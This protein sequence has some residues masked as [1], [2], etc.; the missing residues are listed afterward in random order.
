[1]DAAAPHAQTEAQA[2]WLAPARLGLGL[3]AGLGLLALSRAAKAEVIEGPLVGALGVLGALLPFVLLAGMGGMRARVLGLWAGIAGCVLFAVGWRDLE[4]DQPVLLLAPVMLFIAHHLVQA[5]AAAGRWRAPYG[6]Y[7]DLAWRHGVQL[8]LAAAF[9][10]AMWILLWLAAALFNMLGV[11]F[12]EKLITKDY[13][14]FPVTGLAIAAAV[15]LTMERV[16]L[17]IGARALALTLFSWLLPLLTLIAGA[18][19]AAVPI[20]GAEAVWK[21]AFG[22]GLL[23]WAAVL[24]IFLLNAAYQA[25]E[26]PRSRLL[27]LSGR[28]AALLPVPLVALAVIGVWQRVAQHGLTPARVFAVAGFVILAAYALAYAWAAF[29]RRGWL[30]PL[31]AANIVCAGVAVLVQLALLSPLADPTRLAIA[32]QLSRLE[33]GK[34][35]ADAFDYAFLARSGAP[36]KAA[37]ERLAATPGGARSA[38]LARAALEERVGGILDDAALRRRI[39]LVDIAAA[40]VPSGLYKVKVRVDDAETLNEACSGGEGC[41]LRR[42][43]FDRDGDTD[44]LLFRSNTISVLEPANPADPGQPWRVAA[45]ACCVYGLEAF[46]NESLTPAPPPPFPDTMVGEERLQWL[47]PTEP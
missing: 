29:S 32:S 10:G 16:G 39:L 38:I 45:T 41:A 22:S 43:D 20:R 46:R 27:G 9:T 14:A 17:V 7:F 5:G 33:H 40:E 42:V 47:A 8:A 15:H 3:A 23:A 35:D 26:Q 31:G 34:V 4:G 37:L 25:G 13:F 19:L 28:A 44:W 1:M 21:G 6:A 2:G 12:I 24:L 11:G 36:G 18:F 30:A